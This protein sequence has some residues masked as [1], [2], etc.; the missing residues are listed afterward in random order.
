M[1]KKRAPDASGCSPYIIYRIISVLCQ[2]DDVTLTL[3]RHL[4]GGLLV[5]VLLVEQ[6]Q[7]GAWQRLEQIACAVL[8]GQNDVEMPCLQ[9]LYGNFRCLEACGDGYLQVVV[10]RDARC[11]LFVALLQ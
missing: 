3:Q 2:S 1:S 4:D 9:A 8:R 10:D 6:Q 7:T 11:H 5:Y